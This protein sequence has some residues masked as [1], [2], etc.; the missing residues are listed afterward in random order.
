[1]H[2]VGGLP[3]PPDFHVV[4]AIVDF[5]FY[6]FWRP[7]LRGTLGKYVNSQVQEPEI[8][9]TLNL[10]WLGAKLRLLC[11][12]YARMGLQSDG[13]HRQAFLARFQHMLTH[14]APRKVPRSHH[15]ERTHLERE[16]RERPGEGCRLEDIPL[17]TTPL[18]HY[19]SLVTATA[20]SMSLFQLGHYS[21]PRVGLYFTLA[22]FCID[23]WLSQIQ[24]LSAQLTS[25]GL[26]RGCQVGRCPPEAVQFWVKTGHVL[27][28][29]A[30]NPILN[31]QTKETD[32][33][34][35]GHIC[36]TQLSGMPSCSPSPSC[37]LS[38]CQNTQILGHSGHFQGFLGH[39]MEASK[40]LFGTRNI[41]H[42]CGLG[43]WLK[44]G[45][46]HSC[47]M[48]CSNIPLGWQSPSRASQLGPCMVVPQE[49]QKKRIIHA[50]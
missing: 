50:N 19:I 2:L 14:V 39:I 3:L 20:T 1:M 4:H 22:I 7:C 17:L 27:P 36:P 6:H 40:R 49:G 31:G 13:M 41:W 12:S 21:G 18:S 9:P 38:P 26:G 5:L 45:K 44:E 46:A 16:E 10:R 43:D 15:K 23:V 47:T 48:P 28:K 29:T 42:C 37:L 24:S 25:G 8:W 35:R 30:P 33:V 32:D 11:A 34:C